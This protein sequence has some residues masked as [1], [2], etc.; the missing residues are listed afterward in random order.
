MKPL[1]NARLILLR[2]GQV[3]EEVGWCQKSFRDPDGRRCLMGA[4][5]LAKVG[6]CYNPEVMNLLTKAVLGQP[7]RYGAG[8]TAWNDAPGRTKE[9]VIAKLNEAAMLDL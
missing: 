6:T 2:A 9:E 5:S 1:N 7:E 3:L 8:L 4:L